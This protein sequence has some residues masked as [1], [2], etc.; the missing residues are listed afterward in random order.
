MSKMICERVADLPEVSDEPSSD[1]AC[2]IRRGDESQPHLLVYECHRDFQSV[3]RT[4]AVVTLT[5]PDPDAFM[6]NTGDEELPEDVGV[7]RWLE[8]T[9]ATDEAPHHL[10][11][12][13]RQR[14]VEVVCAE[15]SLLERVYHAADAAQAMVQHLRSE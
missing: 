15:F 4:W 8:S 12:V 6:L 11:L 1:I 14:A 9:A 7:Y 3:P 2:F 13:S 5:C 10:V